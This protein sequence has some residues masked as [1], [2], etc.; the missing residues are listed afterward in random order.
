MNVRCCL[1]LATAA[2]TAASAAGDG[3]AS[4][5]WRPRMHGVGEQ[6]DQLRQALLGTPQGD[7]VQTATTARAMAAVLRDGYG[8]AERREVPG[9]ARMA[10]AAESW[11]LQIALEARAAHGELAAQIFAD[12]VGRH[13]RECHDA[14]ERT[15]QPR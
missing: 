1:V 3:R 6:R 8:K 7:L 9:F 2:C 14:C 10:R 4:G 12:G 11:L 15:A 5:D 13:C